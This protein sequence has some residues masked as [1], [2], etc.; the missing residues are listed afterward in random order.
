MEAVSIFSK[1]QACQN[2]RGVFLF[3]KREKLTD[4]RSI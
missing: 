3:N 1:L 4:A 2:T